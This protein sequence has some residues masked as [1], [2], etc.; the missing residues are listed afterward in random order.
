MPHRSIICECG[1]MVKEYLAFDQD[2]LV[3]D[4]LRD[5]EQ[6]AEEYGDYDVQYTYAIDTVGNLTGVLRL[7]DLVLAPRQ[8]PISELIIKD[9][10]SVFGDEPL[11]ALHDLFE[12]HAFIGIP[13]VDGGGRL[14]GIVLRDAVRRAENRVA[15]ETFLES[16][17]IIGGEELRSMS[18]FRRAGRRLSWLSINILLNVAAASV[19]A[20]YQDTLSAVIVLAVFLPIISDMSGCSGNQAVAVSIR[21]LTLGV[22]RPRDVMRVFWKEGVIGVING[23]VLGLLLGGIAFVWKGNISLGMVVCA[24]LMANTLLAVLLGGAIPLVLRGLKQDPALASGPILT[25]VTDMCGFF[26]VLS[27]A[28]AYLSKLTAG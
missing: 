5:M 23:F 27:L 28:T 2:L 1:V 13:V 6:K 12:D 10:V 15:E 21:E 24:A 7:R 25:T 3:A 9:P 11:Q 18:F 17:G 4:V 19:I 26:L 14:L 20:L 8:K 16:T 22:I